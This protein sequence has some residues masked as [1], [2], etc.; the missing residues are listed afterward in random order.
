MG[1]NEEIEKACEEMARA[2]LCSK[3]E[4]MDAVYRIRHG[5]V[6]GP[7]AAA[8]MS[9]MLQE[10]AEKEKPNVP[11]KNRQTN[12]KETWIQKTWNYVAGILH[13]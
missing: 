7:E 1:V 11:K 9:K 12:K 3:D 13:K 8:A 4:L 2:V 10:I 6:R 5:L